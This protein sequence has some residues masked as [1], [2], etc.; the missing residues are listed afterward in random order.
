MPSN[1]NPAA[2]TGSRGSL[3]TT[4][5]PL[6]SLSDPTCPICHEPYASPSDPN[7]TRECAVKIDFIAEWHGFKRCCGHII[8]RNCLA[9]QVHCGRAWRNKCPICRDVWFHESVRDVR[10]EPEPRQ[11]ARRTDWGEPMAPFRRCDR[12]EAK[13]ECERRRRGRRWFQERLR[14]AL[15]IDD[16]GGIVY[17]STEELEEKL[18]TV[19]LF[20][21]EEGENMR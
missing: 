11:R 2:P 14:A 18:R 12:L 6:D 10:A 17:G 20:S 3:I 9:K 21:E 8:G 19:Y 7:P 5:I 4:A 16:V 15:G 1:P 13:R